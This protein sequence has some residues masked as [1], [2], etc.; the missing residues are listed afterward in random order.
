MMAHDG[1][2]RQAASHTP[3]GLC[4]S[5][6]HVRVVESDRGSIF[7][8]CRR[9]ATDARFARYPALPVRWCPGY[10]PGAGEDRAGG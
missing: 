10:E 4:A 7:Y 1:P 9:A 6:R 5:C 2:S 3:A 8:Q